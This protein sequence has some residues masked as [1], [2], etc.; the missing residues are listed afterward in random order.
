MAR[1]LRFDVAG[2]LWHVTNRGNEQKPIFRDDEDREMFLDLLARSA[3]RFDWLLSVHTLMP[4]HYHLTIELT[5]DKSLQRGMHW[6]EGLYVKRFNARHRR[7]GHLFQGTYGGQ[8][9][10]KDAYFLNVARYIVWNPVRA[11][12]CDN[13]GDYR[14]SSYRATAGLDP[15][16]SWLACNEVLRMMGDYENARSNYIDF[17]AQRPERSPW[18]DLIGQMFLG[19][20]EWATEVRRRLGDEPLDREHPLEQR[21]VGRP[22]VNEIVAVVA[23]A[24]CLEPDFIRTRRGGQARIVVAWIAFHEGLLRLSEIARSLGLR[25]VSGITNMVKKCEEEMGRNEA[26]RDLVQACVATLRRA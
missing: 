3:R 15:A 16:P 14:W 5:E 17:V 9:I 6:F 19:S 22:S 13:P 23:A 20:K 26:F 21:R 4:N 10:E 7:A 25:S 2:T 8:M 24:T 12:L 11:G 1:P 18:D